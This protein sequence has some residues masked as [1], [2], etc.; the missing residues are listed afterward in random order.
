MADFQ[1]STHRTKWIFTP[2]ELVG[3]FCFLIGLIFLVLCLIAENLKQEKEKQKLLGNLCD[4]VVVCLP[5]FSFR[6]AMKWEKKTVEK[7]WIF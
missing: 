3:F 2:Q 1:T 7:K 6:L 4:I 5:F